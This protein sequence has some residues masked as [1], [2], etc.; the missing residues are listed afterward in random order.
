MR[1]SRAESFFT[2]GEA[3][4]I[5]RAIGEAEARTSGEIAVMVVDESDSYDEAVITGGVCLG[6]AAAFVLTVVWFRSSIW[7]FVPLTFILCFAARPL[8]RFW[9]SLKLI[10]VAGAREEE[11]VRERAVQA[12]YEKGLHRTRGETGVLFFLSILERRVWVLAD[13]GIYAKM[14]QEDLDGFAGDISRGVR[15]G[16]AAEALVK[17]VARAGDLLARHF[18]VT[19]ENPQELPD[20]VITG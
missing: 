7:W 16:R 4:M 13:R 18:P 11:A 8:L 12:F 5:K 9:P 19:G 20:D 6:G 17:A 3:E 1:P 14:K 15:E 10:F 2:S